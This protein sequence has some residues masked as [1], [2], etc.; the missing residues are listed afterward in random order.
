M[1]ERFYIH[2]GDDINKQLFDTESDFNIHIEEVGSDE[3]L[4]IQLCNLLNEQQATISRLEEENEELKEIHQ[5]G[6]K[7]CEK[8]KQHKEAQIQLLEKENEDLREVNKENQLLHEE[9]VKQ[10]E[11]WKNLY[12]IKN[13]EITKVCEYYLTETQFK[14]DTDP[15][16]A[17]KEVINKIQGD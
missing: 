10:C 7:S 1:G 17:V 14:E 8:W 5:K 9:N 16:D 11:R 3:E 4:L 13:A 12:E 6:S 15:N 2:C